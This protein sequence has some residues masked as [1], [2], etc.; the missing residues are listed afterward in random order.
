MLKTYATH[1]CGVGGACRGLHDAGLECVLAVDLWDGALKVREHNLGHKGLCKDVFAVEAQP[2]YAA[3]LLWTS[4]VCQS[5]STASRDKA[6]AKA[7]EGEMEVRDDLYL[8]SV[9]YVKDFRP[10][11]FILENV[12]GLLTY[13]GNTPDATFVQMRKAF[14]ELGY[15]TEYNIID[16]HDWGL[17]QHRERSFIVGSRDGKKGLIPKAPRQPAPTAALILEHGIL[18]AAWGAKTYRTAIEKVERTGIPITVI[19]GNDDPRDIFPTVTCGWGGGATRKK[20]CVVD[21]TPDGVAFLRHPTV[22]EGAQAQGFP[23]DWQWPENDSDAWTMIG[24]AVSP[25]VAKGLVEHLQQI[26]AGER[27]PR[28]KM[29]PKIPKYLKDFADDLMPMID[30]A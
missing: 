24:N 19:L 26:E 12:V 11:Y 8:A 18:D 21:K 4:P 6:S 9:K 7:K 17:P 5:F 23:L 29:H 22:K 13:K 28:A 16:S 2:E 3:D 14:D 10:A 30:F 25:P 15:H 20:V 1:F 27:P